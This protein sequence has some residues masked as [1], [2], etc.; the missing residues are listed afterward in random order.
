[1][2]YHCSVCQEKVEGD[3]LEFI[4]HTEK[5]IIDLIRSKHPSWI[6]KDGICHKCV[7]YYKKQMRGRE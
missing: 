3:A 7:E 6:E 1:M 2:G 5:H 4:D